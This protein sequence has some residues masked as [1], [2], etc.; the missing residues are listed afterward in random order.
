M[1]WNNCVVEFRKQKSDFVVSQAY[2]AERSAQEVQKVTMISPEKK[3]ELFLIR[4]YIIS[5]TFD[6]I[7]K[8]SLDQKGRRKILIMSF[9]TLSGVLLN[10]L[11]V[12]PPFL[13]VAIAKILRQYSGDYLSV[14]GIPGAALS[15]IL[16]L[17]S[18]SCF[19]DRMSFR[20]TEKNKFP[21][22]DLILTFRDRMS[23]ESEV[24]FEKK[25]KLVNRL[26]HV[27]DL[28]FMY[29][30][31]FL[32]G[33][34]TV[35]HA[36]MQQSILFAILDVISFVSIMIHTRDFIMNMLA[37]QTILQLAT[38]FLV[39][40]MDEVKIEIAIAL[41]GK[42]SPS[43][44]CS[45]LDATDEVKRKLQEFKTDA[46]WVISNSMNVFMPMIGFILSCG[47]GT[48]DLI[49]RLFFTFVCS[50]F[51]ILFLLSVSTAAHVHTE[52]K[53]L[54]PLLASLQL[55][56]NVQLHDRLRLDR[57]LKA[58]ASDE[59]PLSFYVSNTFPFT[60][61]TVVNALSLILSLI[62][63]FLPQLDQLQA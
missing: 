48:K 56:E 16:F 54:H 20:K 60:A 40:K 61:A 29:P 9:F 49:M 37:S 28:L 32:H 57:M 30:S 43:V 55:V 39:L 51:C 36:W 6:Q 24:R 44:V 15:F 27:S 63:M 38:R 50:N 14:V 1:H 13:P 8:G 41:E 7:K 12:I 35:Y 25:L 23:P 58:I 19:M 11:H 5:S 26:E 53:S 4:N 52:F 45:I 31:I 42:T 62:F 59:H 33:A 34:M 18:V 2:E 22:L 46:G 21:A 3:Y 17:C 47:I 10:F